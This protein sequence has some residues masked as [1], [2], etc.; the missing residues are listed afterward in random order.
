MIGASELRDAVFPP[1]PHRTACR[2]SSPRRDWAKRVAPVLAK[3]SS[4]REPIRVLSRSSSSSGGATKSAHYSCNAMRRMRNAVE[5]RPVSNCHG[6]H[7]CCCPVGT[8]APQPINACKDDRAGIQSSLAD[9]PSRPNHQSDPGSRREIQAMTSRKRKII[10][11]VFL[12]ML[13]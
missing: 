9:F 13:T 10:R 5:T 3:H 4:R 11:K 2:S 7:Q 6:H 12:E 1:R 8:L